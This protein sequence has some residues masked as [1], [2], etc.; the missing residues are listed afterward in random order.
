MIYFYI[1]QKWWRHADAWLYENFDFGLYE[2]G[3]TA[4]NFL[5]EVTK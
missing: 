4:L 2:L 1:I 3:D 5:I